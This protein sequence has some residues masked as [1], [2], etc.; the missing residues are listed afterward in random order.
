[1]INKREL[2]LLTAAL[3]K[4]E[5]GESRLPEFTPAF[6]EEERLGAR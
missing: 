1:M 4:L 5:E 2:E 6:D 3:E